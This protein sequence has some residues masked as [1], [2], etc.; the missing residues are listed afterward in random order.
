MKSV[1]SS[2]LC[3]FILE[4]HTL[5]T[6]GKKTKCSVE[7][8]LTENGL[9]EWHSPGTEKSRSRRHLGLGPHLQDSQSSG[10][11]QRRRRRQKYS[12][13]WIHKNLQESCFILRSSLP[14]RTFKS[15]S[16][17]LIYSP[18]HN[19]NKKGLPNVSG[20]S[21][22]YTLYCKYV[23]I[24]PL[25]SLCCT[26]YTRDWTPPFIFQCHN[27]SPQILLFTSCFQ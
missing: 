9:Q 27:L 4:L 3:L 25:K 5:K 2:R 22:R 14:C 17:I 24:F 8:V 23:I 12:E 20:K 10:E 1:S 13:A 19:N 6:K 26:H 11:K 21:A 15:A 7:R 16:E 18:T